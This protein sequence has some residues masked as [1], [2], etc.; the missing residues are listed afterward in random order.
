MDWLKAHEAHISRDETLATADLTGIPRKSI[1]GPDNLALGEF[2]IPC[3]VVEPPKHRSSIVRIR[4]TIPA[5]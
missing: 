5:Q 3:I 1:I 2:G 4:V